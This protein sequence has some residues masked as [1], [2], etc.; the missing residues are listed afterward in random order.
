MDNSVSWELE[1]W[2]CSW[3]VSMCLLTPDRGPV[4]NKLVELVVFIVITYKNIRERLFIGAEVT[5][6][7]TSP[8][9]ALALVTAHKS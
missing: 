8:K 9:P 2:I 7:A 4:T 5:Q 1:V 3:N 6:T